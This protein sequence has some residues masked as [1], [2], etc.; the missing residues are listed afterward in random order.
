MKFDPSPFSFK[1]NVVNKEA[2]H[3]NF[4]SFNVINQTG[5]DFSITS[6]KY[7]KIGGD[8]ND[9][10]GL[11]NIE[12]MQNYLNNEAIG[13]QALPVKIKGNEAK[14]SKAK[15]ILSDEAENIYTTCKRQM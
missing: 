10:I 12:A 5:S 11:L 15:A 13:R 9:Y 7:D 6:L 8:Y 1:L 4:Q 3:E 14:Q 2:A